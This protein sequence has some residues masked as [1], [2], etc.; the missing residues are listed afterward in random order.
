VD[1]EVAAAGVHVEPSVHDVELLTEATLRNGD[2]D[3]HREVAIIHNAGG[4]GATDHEG[5]PLAND[6][7][8]GYPPAEGR[9]PERLYFAESD[10]T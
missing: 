9:L 1:R 10:L 6:R 4:C 3:A 7:E 2:A 8:E 5:P